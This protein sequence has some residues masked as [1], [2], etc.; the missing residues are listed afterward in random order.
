VREVVERNAPT[1]LKGMGIVLVGTLLVMTLVLVPFGW[2]RRIVAKSAEKSGGSA[3]PSSRKYYVK[4]GSLG[5]PSE[6]EWCPPDLFIGGNRFSM[7]LAK[8]VKGSGYAWELQNGTRIE[9]VPRIE[10]DAQRARHL[11]EFRARHEAA[12]SWREFRSDEEPGE[13]ETPTRKS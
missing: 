9:F 7:H 13:Q 12:G 8:K 5:V 1:V 4:V 6:Y 3:L 11:E 10:I 2:M